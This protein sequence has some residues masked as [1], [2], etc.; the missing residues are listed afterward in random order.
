MST[1][2]PAALKIVEGDKLQ[3]DWS[4]G[5]RRHYTFRQ[6]R[7]QCPCAICRAKVEREGQDA[8]LLPVLSV[9]ETVPVRITAMEPVGNYAYSISFS[10]GHRT[11][12]YRL[13]LL[14]NLG[15]E[16]T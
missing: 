9:A 2:R 4:D 1:A 6:L 13:E 3:I 15:E 10:D 11:G 12:I 8:S 5:H 16:A 7:D 14:R